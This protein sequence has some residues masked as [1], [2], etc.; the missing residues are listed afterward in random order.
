MSQFVYQCSMLVINWFSVGSLY[1]A[2]VIIF[3]LTVDAM[4]STSAEIMW[5][6]SLSYGFLTIL[7]VSVEPSTVLRVYGCVKGLPG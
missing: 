1:L 4:L 6:F 5:V 2:L 7:Q 3:Q